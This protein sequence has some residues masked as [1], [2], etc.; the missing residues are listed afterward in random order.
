MAGALRPALRVVVFV[1]HHVIGTMNLQ[2]PGEAA[3]RAAEGMVGKSGG[4]LSPW[5]ELTH[6]REKVWLPDGACARAMVLRRKRADHRS[7]KV[8]L[9]VSFVRS[10]T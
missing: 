7:L 6:G 8:R 3:F 9:T 5:F 1:N 4:L 2:D 10:R